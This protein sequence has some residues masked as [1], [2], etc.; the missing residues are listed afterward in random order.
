MDAEML[1]TVVVLAVTMV[2]LVTE[3]AGTVVALGAAVMVLLITGVV[4]QSEA[5][6]G[7]SSPAPFV[8]GALYVL[9]AAASVTGAISGVVERGLGTQR[10]VRF[11]LA[12]F[13]AGT[14]MV[15]GMV[16][17]TPLVALAAPRVVAWCRARGIPASRYLMPLSFA[18]VLGGVVT[19]IGT[20]TNLIVSDLLVASG[21]APLGLF[22]IT[23]IGL[24]VASVGVILVVI[25]APIVLVDRL[26][27]ADQLRESARQ[28]TIAMRVV[29]G[30]SAVGKTIEI[31]GLRHLEGV[32]VAGVDRNGEL[33]TAGADTVL[34]GDDTLYCVGDVSLVVD[35]QALDGLES[36]ETQHLIQPG[37][38]AGATLFEAVVGAG[39]AL[40]NATLAASGFRTRHEAAVV[41]VHR[42][43]AELRGKLGVITLRPG[44]VLLILADPGFATRAQRTG[45]FSLITATDQQ[46]PVARPRRWLVLLVAVVML[47]AT[48]AGLVSLLVASLVAAGFVL[49]AK[50]LTLAEARRAVD[51]NVVLTLALSIGLGNAVAS[52]GLAAAVG[53]WILNTAGGW[54][55][56]AVL[57][58]VVVAGLVLTELVSNAGAVAVLFPVVAAISM[59]SGLE[60]RTLAV[61]LL[62]TASC[63]FLSPIGYQTNL[64]VYGMGGYRFTDFARLGA[65][66]T[67]WVACA[68]VIFLPMVMPLS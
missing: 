49:V 33:L 50:V 19:V 48:V 11:G 40:A 5:L 26:P 6:A 56:R 47:A 2:A 23:P 7:F 66:L 21:Q 20:S 67:L 16:P 37:S 27:V 18:S 43:D 41:A 42:A 8:I 12:R 9:A 63:S 35:L 46:P 38:M 68:T 10:G 13:L 3:R 53:D 24:I 62:I 65:P 45:D 60:L 44:D 59:S 34:H 29:P 39:S 51:L 54:G 31:A 17:N 64:M 36:A 57:A 15:S 52:S 30:G 55:D 1:I 61:A 25:L 58:A 14:T 32:F 28:Y 22:E 4:D